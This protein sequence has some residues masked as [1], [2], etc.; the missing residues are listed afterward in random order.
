MRRWVACRRDFRFG[1]A[2]S[3]TLCCCG[4]RP[5]IQRRSDAHRGRHGDALR[6][7]PCKPRWPQAILRTHALLGRPMHDRR[8]T[9]CDKLAAISAFRRP[10]CRSRTRRRLPHLR[11]H[12]HGWRTPRV[13]SQPRRPAHRQGGCAPLLEVFI[14]DFDAA[15]YGRRITVEFLHKLRDEERYATSTPS[16]GRSRRRRA[17]ARVFRHEPPCPTIPS[18]TTSP[19]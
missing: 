6:A 16:R 5:P 1:K 10:T 19:R 11:G 17:G 7:P 12:V 18:T 8:V 9:P 2:R 4:R 15:I 14:F 13:A 3:G